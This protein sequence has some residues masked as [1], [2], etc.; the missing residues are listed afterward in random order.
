MRIFRYLFKEVSNNVVA[1]ASMLLLIFLSARFV[2]YLGSAASGK[3]ADTAI[4]YLILYRLPSFLEIILPLSLFLG[5]MLGYGRLYVE[6]E[7][8][9]LQASGLSRRRLLAYTQGPAMIVTL[10]VAACSFY[11]TPNGYAKFEK[12]VKSP[13]ATSSFNMLVSGSFKKMSQGNMVVYSGGL[14]QDKKALED[15]FVAYTP[16]SNDNKGLQI[17]KAKRGAVVSSAQGHQYL[18]FYDG[19]QINGRLDQL[20][21]SMARYESAGLL[22]RQHK[23]DDLL[24]YSVEAIPTSSLFHDNPSLKEQAALQWRLFMPI[25]VP[26]MAMIAL[27]LSETSHRRGRYIKLLPGIV[28]FFLYLVLLGNARSQIEKGELSPAVGLWVVHAVFFGLALLL[29][30]FASIKQAFLIRFYS[31]KDKPVT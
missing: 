31:L 11:L 28:I 18:E 22:L 19:V 26:I 4:F 12:L 8:V 25:M 16:E 13:Q 15:V 2:R 14:S 10:M 30:N 5:I 6:S 9:V 29:F 7:M 1:V 3:Y 23:Q 24:Q 20:D 21:Y 27:A 17:I